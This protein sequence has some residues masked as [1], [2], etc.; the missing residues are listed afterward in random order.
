MHGPV[1]PRQAHVEHGLGYDTLEAAAGHAKQIHEIG[2]RGP[3]SG[4]VYGSSC[5]TISGWSEQSITIERI[6]FDEHVIFDEHVSM[7]PWVPDTMC[8]CA[9]VYTAVSHWDSS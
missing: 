4:A 1:D 3:E 7:P 5:G 6:R 8:R 9:H 2:S